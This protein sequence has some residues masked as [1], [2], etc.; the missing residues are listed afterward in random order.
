MSSTANC[1]R[2]GFA[3]LRQYLAGVPA[4]STHRA[5]MPV[6]LRSSSESTLFALSIIP[7]PGMS[8][9]VQAL[10][11]YLSGLA[12]G[13]INTTSAPLVSLL[14]EA[15]ADLQGS[16]AESTSESK[17]DRLEKP[18]WSPPRLTF[19]LERHGG[20]VNGST[21]ADLHEW[22]VDIE[23]ATASCQTGKWLQLVPS[24]PRLNVA[25]LVDEVLLAVRDGAEHEYVEWKG[26]DRF[27][28]RIG[29]VIP[30][31]GFN[32]TITA[33]RRRFR[34]SLEP[35]L[36]ELGWQPVKGARANTYER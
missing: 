35:Q 29:K 9:S 23:A 25:P 10:R 4:E 13:P 11:D 19:L 2:C 27:V 1:E 31:A 26:P 33:R 30:D 12:D 22:T 34:K 18:A 8:A 15:W 16:D 5:E 36:L 6:P 14:V 28:V 24:S 21:R 20:T 7:C 32:Q 3:V 17:L